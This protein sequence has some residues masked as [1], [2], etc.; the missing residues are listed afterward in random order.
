MRRRSITAGGNRG[1]AGGGIAVLA[2]VQARTGV[3]RSRRR[4]GIAL[5]SIAGGTSSLRIGTDL[6]HGLAKGAPNDSAYQYT[7]ADFLTLPTLEGIPA[8]LTSA[9]QPTAALADLTEALMGAGIVHHGYWMGDLPG[10]IE[11]SVKLFTEHETNDEDDLE[12]LDWWDFLI[13]QD[14]SAIDA[15]YCAENAADDIRQR[16]KLEGKGLAAFALAASS[17]KRVALGDALTK[18]MGHLRTLGCRPQ[19]AIRSIMGTITAASGLCGAWVPAAQMESWMESGWP[20][21][22]EPDEEAD[23]SIQYGFH[24]SA[25]Q[26][27]P[28]YVF[29]WKRGTRGLRRLVSKL[30]ECPPEHSRAFWI[31]EGAYQLSLELERW[32]R[33]KKR[34]IIGEDHVCYIEHEVY[35]SMLIEWQAGGEPDALSHWNDMEMEALSQSEHHNV[36]WMHAFDPTD[37]EATKIAVS[38]ARHFLRI[39]GRLDHLLSLID[40]YAKAPQIATLAPAGVP[41]ANVFQEVRVLV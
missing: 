4:K 16:F 6:C 22:E 13:A 33:G 37:R 35:P 20:D 24:S 30:E 11:A 19:D 2:R 10:T 36:Q 26:K 5:G 31:V 21:E 25:W 3:S 39:V 28:P 18:L 23:E 38:T 17:D 15:L 41:L 9:T 1:G 27:I 34:G 32:T 7:A 40:G 12:A 29:S 8:R 14:V